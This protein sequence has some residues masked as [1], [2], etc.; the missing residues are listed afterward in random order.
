MKI[1][2]L[3]VG[4]VVVALTACASS[5]QDATDTELLAAADATPVPVEVVS[6][7]VEPGTGD[8]A[9]VCTQEKV[10]GKLIPKRV[11]K[12]R[13]QIEKD[14]IEGRTLTESLQGHG[15]SFDQSQLGKVGG[16]NR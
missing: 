12:T 11:C 7:P 9:L 5:R 14:R 16:S 13:A 3:H 6:A 2:Y 10:I 8:D 4:L 15:P 1:S